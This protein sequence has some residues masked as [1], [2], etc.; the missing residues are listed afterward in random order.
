[1]YRAN[2]AN[3]SQSGGEATGWKKDIRATVSGQ[4]RLTWATVKEV[5]RNTIRRLMDMTEDALWV[6]EE[7]DSE[8]F[9]AG[10]FCI[11]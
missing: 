6:R 7:M 1:M 8:H 2:R 9:I 4:Q 11:T 10:R 5:Q 3:W